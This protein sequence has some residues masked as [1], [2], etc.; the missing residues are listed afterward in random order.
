M[1]SRREA[2]PTRSMERPTTSLSSFDS[3]PQKPVYGLR[4]RLTSSKTDMLRTSH[5]SVSTTLST[6]DNCLS[7]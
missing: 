5:F 6:R 2:M 1:R 7:V 4:P 3:V